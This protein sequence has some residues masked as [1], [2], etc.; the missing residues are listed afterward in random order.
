MATAALMAAT[1]IGSYLVLTGGVPGQ[2]LLT[3]PLVA[4][5]LVANLIPAITL[6]V[7]IGR[8]VAK[9]RAARS[10]VGGGGRLHVRLV[11]IFSLIATVPMVL[12]V[13]FAS[14]LFQYGVEF[15]FSDPVRNTLESAANVAQQSYAR[16]EERVARN[17]VAMAGDVAEGLSRIPLD[18]PRFGYSFGL[19]LFQRDLSEGMLL[20]A[21][22]NGPV[23]TLL[24]INPYN[25]DIGKFITPTM[26]G[27]LRSGKTTV[28]VE[29]PNG[30]GALTKLPMG[31]DNYLYAARID[32]TFGG[33]LR[34]A[35]SVLENYRALIER[36]RKL[37]LQFNAA[38]FIVALLIVALAVWIALNVADRLVRPVGDL[39]G[40]ARRVAAGDLTARVANPRSHDEV[41]TLA[42]AFNR[43][44]ERL[45]E[46]TGALDRRRALTEAVLSGVT[47]GVVAVDGERRVRLMNS[48]ARTML[49]C[50]DG[51]P[52]GRPLAGIGPELDALL[53]TPRR[54]AIVQATTCDGEART[55]AVKIVADEG[56]HV[57][58]FDDITQQLLDQRRAAWSDVARRIAH[59]IKN[60][61][62]PIQLA[63]ERLKR[64]FGKEI[65]S[66][67]VTFDRLTETIV[68]QVGDLRRMVDEF[69]SFA[70]MP[71]PVF[72]EESLVDIARQALFLH[73]VA[74]PAIRFELDSPDI[75][76]AMVC[77]RRQLGQALTNI[78]KNAVEAIDQKEKKVDS[79][80]SV[81]MTIARSG[82][83]VRITVAD[84]GV[85]LPADRERLVEPYVTTRVRG[86][87]L[88]LAIVKK[89]VEEHLG[90]IAFD[91]RPGG[92]AIV[93]LEFEPAALTAMAAV[94]PEPVPFVTER[95]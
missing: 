34:Q 25:R 28:V 51:V 30:I 73:E 82:S 63:A 72:R 32:P 62:T 69:S 71:K 94:A 76:P 49:A 33:E 52:V 58:T 90:S 55:L 38:L 54:E 9:D 37:Q 68:R 16:E 19:Q 43:M 87:G 83:K 92:G 89:I 26:I 60:P 22:P 78:V 44:T 41:G 57:L 91:D 77:D 6:L 56:G 81:A 67:P 23:D 5:L 65:A 79:D 93:T 64:R 80:E 45:E 40:A 17:A 3:P 7:L 24:L 12:V 27:A 18:D 4:L 39:V 86:T 59:E 1:A 85:G 47:A 74:H 14:L 53:D 75:A 50:G 21:T 31:T 35:R 48:S 2:K 42:N 29:S 36:S 88:G 95:G 70:R 10:A 66:D 15:W 20:R 46:Q 13:I 8:R 11:A 61:L 84:S